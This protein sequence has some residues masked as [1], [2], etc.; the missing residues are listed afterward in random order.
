VS[1]PDWWAT[2][3]LALASYRAWR[4]LAEDDILDVPRRYLLRLGD[5]R[6]QGDPVPAG[7]R[8]AAGSFLQ[9]AWCS[10]FWVALAWWAA[11]QITE[12]WTL[13]FAAPFAISALVGFSRARLDPPE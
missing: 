8:A 7:Y 3:L 4:L 12:K 6:K 9:C 5:W 13:V 11:W 10:G 1:V 2:L